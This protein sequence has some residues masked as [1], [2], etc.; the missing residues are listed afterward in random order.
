VIPVVA[1]LAA[2][3]CHT[4][5]SAPF[6]TPDGRCTPGSRVVLTH[7]QICTHKDRGSLSATVRREVVTQYGVPD[8]SGRDGEIDHRVPWFLTHDSSENNLW[9]EVGSIPNPKDKLEAYVYGRVCRRSPAP[10]R[11]STA[12]GIFRGNWVRWYRFYLT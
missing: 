3:A 1:L 9:P 6:V 4:G 7:R 5:G 2:A 11:D 10:M 8:W 12:R